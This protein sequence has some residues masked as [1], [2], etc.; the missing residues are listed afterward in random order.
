MAY[1]FEAR[2]KLRVEEDDWM[3]AAEYA[4][5][6]FSAGLESLAYSSNPDDDKYSIEGVTID[7]NA[8]KEV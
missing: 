4:E 8:S 3:N 1:T 6:F 7:W 2:V 5:E